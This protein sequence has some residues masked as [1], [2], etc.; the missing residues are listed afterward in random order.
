MCQAAAGPCSPPQPH[1]LARPRLTR[2]CRVSL[3]AAPASARPAPPTVTAR[4]G[5]MTSLRRPLASGARRR[6]GKRAGGG[7]EAVAAAG[8]RS[9]LLRVT[10][11]PAP[12]LCRCR[13]P[14]EGARRP[15]AKESGR[16]RRAE[17]P[18]GCGAPLGVL[19]GASPAAWETPQLPTTKLQ[20][21]LLPS[22]VAFLCFSAFRALF[23]LL[24]FILPVNV[25]LLHAQ[26]APINAGPGPPAGRL[27]G[28]TGRSEG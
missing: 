3:A 7:K 23:S 5:T 28:P 25:L 2:R 12:P 20:S 8:G 10:R 9:E 18:R 13:E 21:E 17:F 14:L 27:A 6:P 1:Y 16:G 26:R 11:G 19:R 15:P 24:P 4:R 22:A